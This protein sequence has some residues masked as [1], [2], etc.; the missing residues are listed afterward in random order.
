MSNTK[1]T[2]DITR[3]FADVNIYHGAFESDD[4]EK[5]R[6]NYT[7]RGF[8]SD[9]TILN[10]AFEMFNGDPG[11][12]EKNDLYIAKRYRFAQLR[13]LSVGDIVEIDGSKYRCGP[14]GWSGKLPQTSEK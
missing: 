14:V 9:S 10:R 13:S 12:L 4:P 1:S 8:F 7:S 3:E 11:Y 5:V 6:F 2:A